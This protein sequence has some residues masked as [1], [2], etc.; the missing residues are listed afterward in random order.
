M[1]KIRKK[2]DFARTRCALATL[3][4]IGSAPVM[5]QTLPW[6]DPALTPE[7]RARCSSTHDTGSED[8][9]ASR[10]ERAV[11]RA[12]RSAAAI[13]SARC[14]VFRPADSDVPHHE[15]SGRTGRR[16]LHAS[17]SG[18]GTSRGHR[19]AAGFDPALAFTFGDLMG[20]EADS[21]DCTSSR[22]PA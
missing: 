12:Y 10:R 5:A 3:A 6:M 7:Q 22:A 17:G 19:L 2:F 14:R 15:R 13:R 11:R 18:H 4:F 9:A 16:R 20:K 8:P 1:F 21:S